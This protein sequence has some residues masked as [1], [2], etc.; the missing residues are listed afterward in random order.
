MTSVGTLDRA[1]LQLDDDEEEADDQEGDGDVI[2][3]DQDQDQDQEGDEDDV[4]RLLEDVTDTEGEGEPGRHPIDYSSMI[5]DTSVGTL[6]RA[7]LQLTTASTDNSHLSAA[8]PNPQSDSTSIINNNTND[9]YTNRSENINLHNSTATSANSSGS[10][11]SGDSGLFSYESL[12]CNHEELRLLPP[13]TTTS[14]AAA[15]DGEGDALALDSADDDP[16]RCATDPV[17][18]TLLRLSGKFDDDRDDVAGGGDDD[19]HDN[20]D[21]DVMG[22]CRGEEISNCEEEDV[23]RCCYSTDAGDDQDAAVGDNDDEEEDEGD[24]DEHLLDDNIRGMSAAPSTP[25]ASFLFQPIT[26]A[27]ATGAVHGSNN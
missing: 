24:D 17:A 9:S 2:I 6:D 8:L 21:D 15:T 1:M 12:G 25:A 18:K 10:S 27:T 20:C 4:E 19:D 22:G 11:G 13:I 7:M 3:V 14:L 26:A 5:D 23:V 16:R